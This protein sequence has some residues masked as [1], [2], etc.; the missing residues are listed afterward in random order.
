MIIISHRGNLDGPIV[1]KENCVESID[2]AIGLGFNVEIDVWSKNNKIYLGHDSPEYEITEKW[3]KER[4][5][6]LWIHCKNLEAAFE[7]H[8]KFRCFCSERD[9]F[10]FIS[11]GYIWV[12]DLETMPLS[13]CVIPLLSIEEIQTY[14]FFNEAFAVCTDYP[15]KLKDNLDEKYTINYTFS[16]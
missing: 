3:L 2:T 16:R 5:D 8:K 15:L 13:N 7:L 6:L 14:R 11:K 10:C 4:K 9:P 12:N 1:S